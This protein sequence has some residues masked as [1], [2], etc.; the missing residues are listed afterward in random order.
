MKTTDN[1]QDFIYAKM[2]QDQYK[3]ASSLFDNEDRLLLYICLAYNTSEVLYNKG[4]MRLI[5]N[6]DALFVSKVE[7]TEFLQEFK[8]LVET[9]IGEDVE[10]DASTNNRTN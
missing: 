10:N 7:M 2:T 6:P 1:L 3:E 9:V 4:A 5:T 8:D